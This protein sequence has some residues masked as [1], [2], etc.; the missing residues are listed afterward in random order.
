MLGNGSK[1][2]SGIRNGPEGG[3]TG[4]KALLKLFV[5][6]GGN[7]LNVKTNGW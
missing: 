1:R 3:V 6:S 2:N 5:S 7:Y 4:S